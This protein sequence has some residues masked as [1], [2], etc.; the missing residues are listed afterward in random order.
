M[1][2]R[3][4]RT[5]DNTRRTEANALKSPSLLIKKGS[6]K[7]QRWEDVIL[8]IFWRTTPYLTVL[9]PKSWKNLQSTLSG[10]SQ[11]VIPTALKVYFTTGKVKEYEG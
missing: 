1:I 8:A 6:K 9:P 10:K 11:L 2:L 5:N 7:K 4:R 3:E